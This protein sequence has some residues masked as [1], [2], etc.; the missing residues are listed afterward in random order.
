MNRLS[1]LLEMW[2][3]SQQ[4]RLN[5]LDR[6]TFAIASSHRLGKWLARRGVEK[7]NVRFQE[8]GRTF[9]L[10]LR[11]N[12]VD[13]A[14]AH[15]IFVNRPYDIS[16]EAGDIRTILDLGGNVGFGTLLFH[17]YF[18]SAS[19]A[20]VEPL[21]SNMQLLQ[22]TVA[23]NHIPATLFEAAVGVEDGRVEVRVADDPTASSITPGVET[24]RSITAQQ[25]SVPSIMKKMGWR[26]IDLL[27]IDIEGY[28]KTLFSSGN[29][30]LRH[31]GLIVGEAHAHVQYY[32]E[33]V[34][35]DLA[36][37]GFRVTLKRADPE[38]GLVVFIA[39]RP[40]SAAKALRAS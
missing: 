35:R 7:V 39:R 11:L 22:Q 9:V 5:P 27:K 2:D 6:L 30:W 14:L 15:D 38:F 10:P 25:I 12:G 24:K 8:S 1:H 34:V 29:D 17:A 40:T 20:T 23:L 4:L 18:P 37:F 26:H 13:G 32:F 3:T 19:I 31:V 16:S 36:P 21:P 33:D 28:E